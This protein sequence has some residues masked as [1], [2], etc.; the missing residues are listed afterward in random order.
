MSHP[1]AT[2]CRHKLQVDALRPGLLGK[3]RDAFALRYCAR[4]LV[5]VR[6]PGGETRKKY[7]NSGLGHPKELHALLVQV[8]LGVLYAHCRVHSHIPLCMCLLGSGEMVVLLKAGK[9]GKSAASLR[10]L[11]LLHASI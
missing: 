2:Q 8:S 6:G 7:D 9:G 4:K 3:T 11:H 5:P 10:Y 1:A